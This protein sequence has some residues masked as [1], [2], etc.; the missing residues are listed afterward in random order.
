MCCKSEQTI[1]FTGNNGKCFTW[2][3]SNDFN[4]FC[5]RKEKC[6][7]SAKEMQC[8]F[9]QEWLFAPSCR[10]FRKCYAGRTQSS[11][12]T[13][14]LFWCGLFLLSKNTDVAFWKTYWTKENERWQGR[15][16][17][18]FTSTRNQTEMKQNETFFV[19]CRW[20]IN[21]TF[22]V[23]DIILCQL[24]KNTDFVQ[25]WKSCLHPV[26]TF[27][28]DFAIALLSCFQLRHLVKGWF[29][30]KCLRKTSAAPVSEL[31]N[32]VKE[33]TTV[34]DAIAPGLNFRCEFWQIFSMSDECLNISHARY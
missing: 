9:F 18:K 21:L 25:G 10:F 31:P 16:L 28:F 20:F 4:V 24:R 34:H 5:L 15:S 8:E 11:F 2:H 33:S 29:G 30:Q 1:Q 27:V 26:W 6:T 32:F 7:Q 19:T 22:F 13:R 12:L 3:C 14:Y 17:K 23:K